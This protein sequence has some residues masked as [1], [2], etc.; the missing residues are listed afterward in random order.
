MEGRFNAFEQLLELL[1]QVIGDAAIGMDCRYALLLP[2]L[3]SSLY[4]SNQHHSMS[5][6]ELDQLGLK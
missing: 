1:E 5:V 6:G 4:I 2:H 3:Y